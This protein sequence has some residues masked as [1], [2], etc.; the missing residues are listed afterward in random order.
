MSV[1]STKLRTSPE[2]GTRLELFG[3]EQ[4]SKETH[5]VAWV[6]LGPHWEKLAVKLPSVAVLW[7][8]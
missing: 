2:L 1:S 8:H 7:K 3:Q 6:C 4:Q 5:L